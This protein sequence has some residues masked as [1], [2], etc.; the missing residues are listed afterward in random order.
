M[1]ELT[2][3]GR[4]PIEETRRQ[5]G[6]RVSWNRSLGEAPAPPPE[7]TP[8]MSDTAAVEAEPRSGAATD[9]TAAADT[10]AAPVDPAADTT[11]VPVDPAAADTV[12]ASGDPVAADS[13][14]VA[15]STAAGG[16]AQGD[17]IPIAPTAESA[18]AGVPP[19]VPPP[20]GR[21][22]ALAEGRWF[23]GADVPS[24][25]I[26]LQGG[27]SWASVGGFAV[28]YRADQWADPVREEAASALGARVWTAP[29]FGVS[30]FAGWDSGV[31]GA[32]IGR[33]RVTIPEPDTTVAPEP[34]PDTLPGFHLSDRTAVRAGARLALGP[35]DVMGAWH[36]VEVD[37]ILPIGL[38][39]TRGGVA[40]GGDEV[41]GLEVSGRVDLPVG[42]D[43]LSAVGTLMRWDTEGPYRPSRRYTGGLD[44]HNVYKNGNLELW[45]SVLVDGR[46]GML[47][48]EIVGSGEAATF[49]RIPFQQSWDFFLQVRVLTVRIFIRS[50]NITIRRGNQ[51][52]PDRLLPQTRSVY[53]V[54]WTLWN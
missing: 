49:R 33:T 36:R 10:T 37:S 31:R 25:R 3:D 52:F 19:V 2:Y 17:S 16:V 27:M 7:V 43:G 1:P 46:D 8:P 41:T 29:R 26:D 51:D 28:D 5:Y 18:I 38:L 45:T 54:R 32:G 44:F 13:A 35:L 15:D 47:L 22:W 12:A 48:P 9:S 23:G 4:T 20:P 30:L 53:G 6:A 11:A 50:E 39:G 42:F 21:V 40:V 14:A 34:E 24:R